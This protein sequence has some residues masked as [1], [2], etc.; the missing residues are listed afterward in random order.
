MKNVQKTEPHDLKIGRSRLKPKPKEAILNFKRSF[1][2]KPGR[3]R[4]SLKCP[5]SL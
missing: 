4:F 5:P 2:S 3:E 1:V